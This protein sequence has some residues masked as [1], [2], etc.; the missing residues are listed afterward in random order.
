MSDLPFEEQYVADKVSIRVFSEL[1]DPE[2]LKWHQD[3]ETRLIEVIEAGGWFIQYDNELP[4][5]LKE[6]KTYLVRKGEWH[7]VLK[8][9]GNLKIK[10]ERWHNESKSF[11][12]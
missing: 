3:D 4:M 6:N 7:R 12:N 8:G 9:H 11:N 5:P 1:V 2:E 10:I